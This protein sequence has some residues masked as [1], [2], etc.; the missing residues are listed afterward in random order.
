MAHYGRDVCKF[1]ILIFNIECVQ[2][3][4]LDWVVFVNIYRERR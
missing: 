2:T 4:V 3:K 1:Y